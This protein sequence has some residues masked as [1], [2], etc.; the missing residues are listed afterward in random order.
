V[1]KGPQVTALI[2][3]KSGNNRLEP[4]QKE[5]RDRWPGWHFVCRNE[6]DVIQAH[7]AMTGERCSY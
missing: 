2:E 3:Y 6:M 4:G 5:F 1:C 7:Y